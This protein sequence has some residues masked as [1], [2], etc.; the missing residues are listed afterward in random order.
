MGYLGNCWSFI[1]SLFLY[2]CCKI[3][4]YMKYYCL[5]SILLFSL[6]A[7]GSSDDKEPQSEDVTIKCS[8]EKIEAV[9]Q[10]SQYVVNVVCSGKEWTAFASDDCS[11][12]VK[13]NV[14][15]S[16]S[17]QGTATVIV[18]AHTGTTSRTGTVVVKSG[19]TRVSIPLTQAAPLSVSQTEL[20]SNSIGESFV[21]SVIAS[22][23]WNVKSNDSWISAE[24][25]S[26]EIVV[27]T[28]AND[29]KISR[30]GT[31]EVV[32]GAEKVTVTVI[33]ESAE[34]LDINT[35]EGYRLVW[36]DEFNEGTS[37]GND[38]THEVQG[39]GW[40]NNEL[41]NYVN[42][43]ADG[44]RVTELVDGK[45]NI[46]CF[47][48]SDGKI[49]SGRVYAKVNTGWEYGYFEARIML[50]EGKG[51]WPAFWMM[52]VGNDWNTN[53][54]PMC[55][56]I[57]I[58]EEVG[59]VPNEV[60]SSI[61]T[62]DYNHTI[63]TQKTHAMTI[64]QAEGEFHLYALEWTED[65]ITTYVDGKV[66]LAVTKQQLGAGH[67]QWPFHYAFYPIL[68]LAW[69]GD[70]GGMNGV[71]ESALPVTMKVDYVRVFQKK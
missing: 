50:P 48:G 14:M 19:A 35:P 38:W 43:S 61:H 23:E 6:I 70:W 47:K 67:N 59:V 49:Y 24:K 13:V 34:D 41:Q 64:E 9:A 1:L 57:D 25:N 22:G 58:M 33:Q 55:G 10:A 8:L 51:T 37:L 32:A 18:S 12:W 26:G 2:L 31:V 69:G 20:Y 54:W 44:K 71:D 56:E 60:S 17:S 66:Q 7:C 63:G 3:Y 5:L 65:A 4:I 53:P 16:S 21:L 36:H 52:P 68:N 62:Q 30:T 29:A 45:L 40:V 42:G 46:N 28:L 39:A 27:T 11:S 15:G